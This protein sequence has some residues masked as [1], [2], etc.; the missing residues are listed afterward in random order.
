MEPRRVFSL[1]GSRVL[2]RYMRRLLLS[3]SASIFVLMAITPCTGTAEAAGAER[4]GCTAKVPN[5]H[6]ANYTE[7]DIVVHTVPGAEVTG[8]QHIGKVHTSQ[9]GVANIHGI[10]NIYFKISFIIKREVRT[11]TIIARKGPL[12]ETCR[13]S[14][15]PI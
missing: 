1:S 2:P 3:L 7:A 8:T 9:Q 14:F 15:D 12:T 6:P 4:S 11:V 10:A 13:T 5:P